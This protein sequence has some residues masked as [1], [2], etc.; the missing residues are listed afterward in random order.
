[1]PGATCTAAAVPACRWWP[2]AAVVPG[3]L[4]LHPRRPAAVARRGDHARGGGE[5]E[6]ARLLPAGGGRRARVRG[7]VPPRVPD[8]GRVHAVG[9]P[10]DAAPLRRP[11]PGPGHHVRLRRPRPGARRGLPDAVPSAARV[12]LLQG[13]A[14]ARHRVP[15]LV[16]LGLAGGEHPVL[17]AHTGG[18]KPGEPAAAVAGEAALRVLE[19]QPLSVSHTPP[20]HELQRLQW[21]RMERPRL[22]RGA[23]IYYCIKNND[24]D[25]LLLT[26][27][28]LTLL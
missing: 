13:Q 15:R 1:M 6:A 25:F 20:T 28:L 17:D 9:D 8:A 12:P 5:R 27:S 22:Q 14:H 11:R 21:P 16:L 18:G 7:D 2:G 24:I 19:G 3:L 10:A 4:P 26:D 23:V